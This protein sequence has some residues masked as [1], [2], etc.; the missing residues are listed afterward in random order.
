M[1]DYTLRSIFW[2]RQMRG[3]RCEEPGQSMLA[4]LEA[5]WAERAAK[6]A[7]LKSLRTQFLLAEADLQVSFAEE[8]DCTLLVAALRDCDKR[9][10]LHDPSSK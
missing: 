2:G 4:I 6:A 1:G 7:R 10:S 5:E 3:Q 8:I 9:G